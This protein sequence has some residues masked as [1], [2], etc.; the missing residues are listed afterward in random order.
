MAQ[1]DPSAPVKT[2]EEEPVIPEMPDDIHDDDEPTTEELIEM[3]R[4]SLRDVEAGRTRPARKVMAELR[5][6]LAADA[7]AS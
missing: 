4:E 2:K 3:L 5:E 7:N 6:M 1:A